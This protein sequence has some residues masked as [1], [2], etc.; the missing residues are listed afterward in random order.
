[1]VDAIIFQFTGERDIQGAV[2]GSQLRVRGRRQPFARASVC[3]S[4]PA[5]GKYTDAEGDWSLLQLLTGAAAQTRSLLHAHARSACD[6]AVE[7]Q[8]PRQCHKASSE[9][10]ARC[11]RAPAACCSGEIRA[12]GEC[13]L[14]QRSYDDENLGSNL[15]VIGYAGAPRRLLGS[16][17]PGPPDRLSR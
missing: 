2:P 15:A 16:R 9:P 8:R 4:L 14:E 5:E 11:Y 10:A 12:I 1:M 3:L 6:V 17:V 7:G 13:M